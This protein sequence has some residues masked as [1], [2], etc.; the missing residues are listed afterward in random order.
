MVWSSRE[1]EFSLSMDSLPDGHNISWST[2]GRAPGQNELRRRKIIDEFERLGARRR[3]GEDIPLT[4]REKDLFRHTERNL[5]TEFNTIGETAPDTVYLGSTEYGQYNDEFYT[6]AGEQAYSD[7]HIRPRT[8][9]RRP[10][11]YDRNPNTSSRPS[12]S[13]SSRYADDA[14]TSSSGGR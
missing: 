2:T 5:E 7:T 10:K 12:S 9:D 3:A 6:A 13:S 8:G 14:S 4:E 11:P 1:R